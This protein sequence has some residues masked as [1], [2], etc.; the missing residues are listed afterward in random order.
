VE[1]NYCEYDDSVYEYLPICRGNFDKM[2][3]IKIML[4]KIM[5]GK[6]LLGKEG[7]L[8]EDILKRIKMYSERFTV[9]YNA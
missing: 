9:R 7:Y 6:D 2:C 3:C 8:L 5:W 4:I 1:E